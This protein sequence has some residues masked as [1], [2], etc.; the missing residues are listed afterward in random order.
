MKDEVLASMPEVLRLTRAGR[1]Q[2]ATAAIQR[3]LGSQATA[4]A[5]NELTRRA[6]KAPIE[7]VFRILNEEPP[8]PNDVPQVRPA[9]P[10][11]QPVPDRAPDSV[12][13]GQFITGSY[14]NHAGTRT[15]KLYIPSG[16]RKQPLPL[17][18]ML[19][20]CTQNPDDFAAGTRMNQLAEEQSCLVLY[21]AQAQNASTLKCWNWFKESDQHRDRGEP[22]II[23]GITREIMSAYHVDPQRVYIAG[24]SAGGAMAVIM[25]TTYPDL[26]AAA[27]IHSGLPYAAAH[28]LPSAYAAMREGNKTNGGMRKGKAR[29]IQVGERIIPI[30]VFHGDRDTTVHPCNGARVIAQ[31]QAILVNNTTG[32]KVRLRP[33]ATV[34]RG[35]VENGHAY[36]RNIYHDASGQANVEL[37]LVH[38]AGHAWSGGSSSGS[39]TDPRGPNATQEMMRFFLEH[40]KFTCH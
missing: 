20:G 22:S 36:T 33:Q 6:E 2:E 14:T 8:Q 29:R 40:P 13:G 4:S 16:Y 30:I 12:P 23:A 27:G 18:V 21:P 17:V 32:P 11:P 1:L 7:G 26:Y 39:F 10:R 25:G 35:Q 3:V 34:Q 28:D 15:Y 37:W 9:R 19:H 24:L 5:V 31:F 38:G